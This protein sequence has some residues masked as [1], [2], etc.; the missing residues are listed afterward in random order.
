M[1]TEY[2]FLLVWLLSTIPLC[3]PFTSPGA[4]PSIILLSA[5]FTSRVSAV[6]TAYHWDTSKL[7]NMTTV[8]GK[9]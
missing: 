8:V 7:N 5:A 1:S 9:I 2:W 3:S 4:K 6:S